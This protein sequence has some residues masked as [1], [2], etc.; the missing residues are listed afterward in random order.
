MSGSRRARAVH[1]GASRT[2]SFPKTVAPGKDARAAS[3]TLA[4]PIEEAPDA[5]AD[6]PIGP[7]CVARKRSALGSPAG[8]TREPDGL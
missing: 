6:A 4:A 3:A 2:L 1:R 7:R 5:V 8:P